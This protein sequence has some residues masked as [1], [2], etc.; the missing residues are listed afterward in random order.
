MAEVKITQ[1]NF[2]SEVLKSDKPVL[3]DFFATWCGPCQMLMPIIEELS[4]EYD[5]KVKIATLDIDENQELAQKYQVSSVPSLV[6]FKDGE[7]VERMM[8]LQPK[9]I[10][11]EKL[12]KLS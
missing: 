6:I 5:G 1:D 9:E 12:D 3:V 4:E 2:E 10:L 7:E 8:G 11:K